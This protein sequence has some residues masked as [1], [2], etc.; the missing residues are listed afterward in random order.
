MTT[1]NVST[2][3]LYKVSFDLYK[4]DRNYVKEGQYV[5]TSFNY[6]LKVWHEVSVSDSLIYNCVSI[7]KCI[8]KCSAL[9]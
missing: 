1:Q 5:A 6:G 7:H 3:K 9:C 8:L 2:E 4:F